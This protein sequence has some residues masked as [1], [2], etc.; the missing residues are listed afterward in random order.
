MHLAGVN[1][2]GR[3]KSTETKKHNNRK[4]VAF[5]FYVDS[6][7]TVFNRTITKFTC[8]YRNFRKCFIYTAKTRERKLFALLKSQA[9]QTF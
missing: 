7:Q 4:H 6:N 9:M 1:E 5:T 8:K 3:L 2:P